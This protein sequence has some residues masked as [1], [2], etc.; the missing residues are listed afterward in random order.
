MNL[1]LPWRLPRQLLL[2]L[3]A[4]SF[5]F[6]SGRPAW[7][8]PAA[9]PPW[10]KLDRVTA[11]PSWLEGIARVRLYVSA[12]TLEG[13]VIPISGKN[14]WVLQVGSAKKKLPY[15]TGQFKGVQDDD[16][17]VM[18]VVD[19]SFEMAAD[20]PAIKEAAAAFIG[21]LP[22]DT[23][24]GVIGY[25]EDVEGDRRVGSKKSAL[26]ALNDLDG[27]SVP[28]P[29]NLIKAV[30]YAVKGLRK[31]KPADGRGLRKIIVVVSDGR[32]VEHT[33]G[34]FRS[35]ARK[36]DRYDIRIHTLAYT[37][38]Q[39]REPMRGL[40]ELSKATFGT[41][42]L[43]YSSH[44]FGGNFEQLLKEIEQ[45]YVL[46]YYVP[47]DE[48]EGKKL[49]V[50]AKD[51]VSNDGKVKKVEC[52]KDECGGGAMCA[53]GTCVSRGEAGG[54][55]FLGW[56]LVI[57]GGLVG[58][59]VL[60]VGIGYVL[61]RRQE[62]RAAGQAL[63]AAMAEN[64]AAVPDHRI[65]GQGP[66]GGVARAPT[67]HVPSQGPGQIQGQIPGQNP[68]QNPG[69]VPGR[70]QPQGRVPAAAP[71]V[72]SFI[73]LS[74]AHQGRTVPVHHGF[75]MGKAPDCQLVLA[76]DNFASSHHAHIELD[77]GGGCTLVDDHSTNGTFV[78]GVRSVR[79]RLSSG[80]L[81]KV[82]STEMRF[83]QG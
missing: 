83:L 19:T 34:R 7:A 20:L 66:Q 6:A 50:L 71:G 61:T 63:A 64:A 47:T 82:G 12:I 69:Q 54:R 18:L 75:R 2:V 21:A 74:G 1:V 59:L 4:C 13:G 39:D 42:R 32:D 45:Q 57:G 77:K 53:A 60:L 44:S 17:A 10:L 16:V 79:Q 68:G 55:G 81:V 67:G 15:L 48:L 58:L 5:V 31:A 8:K 38:T 51:I 26:D 52:G 33:A 41:F 80:M 9:G 35:V 25:S 29:V 76:D 65:V 73:V 36:A 23:S 24:V 62:R 14:E 37:T 27:A 49:K 28:S 56:I 43:V 46:T 11:E 72:P 70:I 22:K 40:A 3:V 78:N 30:D